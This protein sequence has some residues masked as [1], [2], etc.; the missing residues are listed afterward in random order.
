[1][2]IAPERESGEQIEYPDTGNCTCQREGPVTHGHG[3]GKDKG[4]RPRLD[5]T[6]RSVLRREG[7]VGGHAVRR[8]RHVEDRTIFGRGRHE[9]EQHELA[10]A[11]KAKA[12][13]RDPEGDGRGSRLLT[14]ARPGREH[15]GHG[16]VL[17]ESNAVDHTLGIRRQMHPNLVAI[18][19]EH[20]IL[21]QLQFALRSI[22]RRLEPCS[23]HRLTGTRN[24]NR[25][26]RRRRQTGFGAGQDEKTAAGEPGQ[27]R[28]RKQHRLSPPKRK[29]I[30]SR[31][32]FRRRTAVGSGC[33][34]L[35]GEYSSV[36]SAF[37]AIR[38]CREL[39][40]RL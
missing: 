36:D 31:V 16:A 6:G 13:V 11:R 37:T 5:F 10:L 21:A 24:L 9:P 7:D 39:R 27:M 20:E 8:L 23:I 32:Y 2:C 35:V 3:S 30:T 17:D 34:P 33:S 25:L 15:P 26:W 40:A 1:M 28:V 29:T 19:Q 18:W 14:H 4:R 38:Q 12:D 22:R